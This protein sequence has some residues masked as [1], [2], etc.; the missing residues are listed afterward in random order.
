MEVAIRL[1]A[2]HSRRLA[3]GSAV[4]LRLRAALP[5]QMDG[6]T[7]LQ[8]P[9]Q[10]T[11]ESG[12]DVAVVGPSRCPAVFDRDVDCHISYGHV[13]GRNPSAVINVSACFRA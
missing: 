1:G 7:W 3:Q 8:E 10:V 13:A 5:V 9:C 4:E 6:E 2:R 11:V 12:G